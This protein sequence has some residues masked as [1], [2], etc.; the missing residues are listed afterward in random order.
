M[1][2]GCSRPWM[3]GGCEKAVRMRAKVMALIWVIAHVNNSI[4]LSGCYHILQPCFLL[5]QYSRM[6]HCS[7]AVICLIACDG[8]FPGVRL[9]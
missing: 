2:N 3:W 7:E 5:V 1:D 6:S 8:V 9:Y 4:K